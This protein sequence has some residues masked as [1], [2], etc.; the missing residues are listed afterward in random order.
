MCI[1]DSKEAALQSLHKAL[2]VAPNS[3]EAQ[4][5]IMMLELDAGRL[6]EALA[7]AREV[8]KQR[9]KEAIGYIFEGDAQVTKKA[10][11]DAATAYRAGLKQVPDAS[12][13]A[14]KLHAVLVLAGSPA[15][16]DKFA[17]SWLKDHAKDYRFRLYL[18]EQ[19]TASKDY[20]AAAKQYR[21][22]L[23]AQ[24]NNPS[25]LNNMAW[26]AGQMKDPKAIEYAEKANKL[27][28]NQPALMDTLG[29]LLVDKGDN[30]RGL[31]LLKQAVALAP[32]AGQ[33]RL[34]YAKSLIKAGQKSEARSEL[35]QL[36][37]LGDK[38]PA[39]AE[40]AELLKGL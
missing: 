36:A 13:L 2:K 29:V 18:A 25:V 10:W 8:Q 9:P 3:L 17:Q 40:V 26:V 15:E 24:P 16:A 23:D 34:N 12:D 37:G 7:V 28:P 21:V 22:L 33:I 27:A 11:A 4:R 35:E 14:V 5:G 19:E 1:R 20:A 6:P 32:Q 38:F 30:A 39:Q 31:E